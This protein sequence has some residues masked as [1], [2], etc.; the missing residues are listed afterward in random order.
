MARKQ[1]AGYNTTELMDADTRV[2]GETYQEEYFTTHSNEPGY[3]T[4]SNQR[5]TKA[6]DTTEDLRNRITSERFED[7]SRIVTERQ[8]D[9]VELAREVAELKRVVASLK[10]KSVWDWKKGEIISTVDRVNDELHNTNASVQSSSSSNKRGQHYA[11]NSTPAGASPA[12]RHPDRPV[13]WSNQRH[14]PVRRRS[15]AREINNRRDPNDRRDQH[16][17]RD[18]DDRRHRTP[19]QDERDERVKNNKDRR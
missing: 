10:P 9:P 16:E 7:S 2:V 18:Q 12:L 19:R 14:S 15:P 4:P 11:K 5:P 17:R 13:H 6:I 1:D 3:N 8:D